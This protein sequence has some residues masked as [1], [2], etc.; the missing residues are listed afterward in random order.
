VWAAQRNRT[1]WESAIG[2]SMDKPEIEYLLRNIRGSEK[3]EA[4]VLSADGNERLREEQQ[5]APY[6]GG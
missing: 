4:R 6:S 5:G 3:V 2:I 1:W